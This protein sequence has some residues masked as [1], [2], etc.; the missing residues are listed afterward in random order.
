L[1]LL[2][3]VQDGRMHG[4]GQWAAANRDHHIPGSPV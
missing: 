3:L 2:L 1:I 4:H